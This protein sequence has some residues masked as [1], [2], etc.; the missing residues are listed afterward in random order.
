MSSSAPTLLSARVVNSL[1]THLETDLLIL[2]RVHYKNHSQ[3]HLALFWRRVIEVDRVGRRLLPVVKAGFQ[4]GATHAEIRRLAQLTSRVRRSTSAIRETTVAR[5]CSAGAD[6]DPSTLSPQLFLAASHLHEHALPILNLTHFLPLIT[7]LI[8][9]ASRVWSL[10]GVLYGH[11]AAV[12]QRDFPSKRPLP[13]LDG[14]PNAPV[15]ASNEPTDA[16]SSSA[17]SVLLAGRPS[18]EREGL[19]SPALA[20]ESGQVVQRS[21]TQTPASSVPGSSAPS[22]PAFDLG[23]RIVRPTKAK[24]SPLAAG[25]AESSPDIGRSET[26]R[27]TP[28]RGISPFAGSSAA[29]LPA[30]SPLPPPPPPAKVRATKRPLTAVDN[31]DDA[32][33]HAP[34]KAKRPSLMGKSSTTLTASPF[35]SLLVPKE[36]SKAASPAESVVKKKRRIKPS[37]GD[38]IDDIFG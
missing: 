26:A 36:P 6:C 5:A 34:P 33:S 16:R 38:E 29:P 2:A 13:K 10:C 1:R 27:N 4:E 9:I 15:A 25:P 12:W 17:K 35:D 11:I 32:V 19:L 7:T 28:P 8:A 30:P 20:A 21:R 23:E 31:S 14:W 24:P 18:S 22:P 37:A 3:H